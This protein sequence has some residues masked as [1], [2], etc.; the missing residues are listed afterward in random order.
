M[1]KTEEEIRKSIDQMEEISQ[2]GEKKE[3]V[4]TVKE[5]VR[6]MED[7]SRQHIR[8]KNILEKFEAITEII[9]CPN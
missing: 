3:E 5:K 4:G 8:K 7:R 9:I 6:N 1:D 2:K